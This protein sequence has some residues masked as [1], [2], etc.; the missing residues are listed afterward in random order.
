MSCDIK[1]GEIVALTGENGAGKSTPDSRAQR[2]PQ[3]LQGP[4]PPGRKRH[5]PHAGTARHMS[6]TMRQSNTPIRGMTPR[7]AV[8]NAALLRGASPTESQHRADGLF[9]A[10]DMTE[11]AD[12]PGESLSGGIR[13]LT[14]L[15]VTLVQDTPVVLL[16]EPTNDV[17]PSRR[18]LLWKLL[19]SLGS[20]GKLV[21]VTTHNIDEAARYTNRQLIMAHGRIVYDGSVKD[22]TSTG[23]WTLIDIPSDSQLP[24]SLE[25]LISERTPEHITI[26]IPK[27]DGELPRILELLRTVTPNATIRQDKSFESLF[28]TYRKKEQ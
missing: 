18:S 14:N 5:R 21:L 16:D 3:T 7:Q 23:D 12:Q 22:I 25:S 15:A 4:S 26:S 13:R 17:D 19:A 6:A 8:I 24:A 1:S 10:L 9:E 20:K 28:E 27:G 2:Q 11:K